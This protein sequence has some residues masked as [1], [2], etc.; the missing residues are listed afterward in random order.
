MTQP[1]AI[2]AE[3]PAST[4][5]VRARRHSGLSVLVGLLAA[6]ATF[7][8][9]AGAV[10]SNRETGLPSYRCAPGGRY[11]QP[12]AITACLTGEP[13]PGQLF[14]LDLTRWEYLF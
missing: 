13:K 10:P 7:A 3:R 11:Q 4:S 5:G 12:E 2:A 14:E 1:V 9:C 6:C 8:G